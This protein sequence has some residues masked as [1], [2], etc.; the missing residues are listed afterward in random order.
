MHG[1]ERK[2]TSALNPSGQ[3]ADV[4]KGFSFLLLE[5]RMTVK[6]AFG[7][8]VAQSQLRES[9]GIWIW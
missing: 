1:K 7:N 8:G 4:D 6:G 9:Q 3:T 2:K 5:M